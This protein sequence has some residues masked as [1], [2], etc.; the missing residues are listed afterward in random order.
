MQTESQAAQIP[1]VSARQ[2]PG[3]LAPDHAELLARTV[4]GLGYEL[5]DV[6]RAGRGLLRVTIDREPQEGAAG[7]DM[8]GVLHITVDDCE[9]VS[10]H[11]SHLFA[12]EGVDYDRLEVSSPGLDRPLRSGRDFAR[13]AG[14]L[15]KVQLREPVAGKRRF[16][17]RLLGLVAG[18]DGAAERV[19][20]ALIPE[21]ALPVGGGR[22]GVA[23]SRKAGGSAAVQEETVEFALAEI[24]KARLAPEWEFPAPA[25]GPARRGGRPRGKK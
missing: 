23:G 13:F 10:R 6:E 2:R 3:A 22:R 19:R 8:A 12:V 7:A 4:A 9:R 20:M 17:G 21:G 24:E 15:A 11:L 5:V 14:A 16:R 18:A 1:A 25:P